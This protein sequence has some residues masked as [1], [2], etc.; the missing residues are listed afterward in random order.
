MS[1]TQDPNT[2][3]GDRRGPEGSVGVWECGS[4]GVWECGS[5]GVWEC[6]SVG[7]WE[8]SVVFSQQVITKRKTTR[9]WG[10]FFIRVLKDCNQSRHKSL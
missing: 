8:C 1:H 7:V 5:V 6:G 9:A 4:V 10:V 2:R 3:E